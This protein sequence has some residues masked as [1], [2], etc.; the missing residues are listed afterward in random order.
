VFSMCPFL[1]GA[2][3]GA[4]GSLPIVLT[5]TFIVFA[6]GI[7][8]SPCSMCSVGSRTALLCPESFYK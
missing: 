6:L 5:Q 2:L 3:L 7:E 8:T 1:I 4:S